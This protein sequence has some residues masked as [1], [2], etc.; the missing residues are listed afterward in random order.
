MLFL[1]TEYTY[2]HKKSQEKNDSPN[3]KCKGKKKKKTSHQD[4]GGHE[5][6]HWSS[7]AAAWKAE[8][9]ERKHNQM[10]AQRQGLAL[11]FSPTGRC[12]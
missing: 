10:Y 3:N 8:A 6:H 4:G 11:T 1:Y 9:V 7:S 5:V 2:I 12:V